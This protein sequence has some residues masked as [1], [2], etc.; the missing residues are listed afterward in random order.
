MMLQLFRGLDLMHKCSVVNLDISLENILT[1]E[2]QGVGT[3]KVTLVLTDFGLSERVSDVNV[4]FF[5]RYVYVYMLS[6][7]DY[8][9]YH[10]HVC[11]YIC[12]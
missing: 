7:I 9:S 2:E 12:I 11:I 10:H 6:R 3:G 4:S 8:N 1:H 5:S